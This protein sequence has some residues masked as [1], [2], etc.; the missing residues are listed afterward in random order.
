MLSEQRDGEPWLPVSS[1]SQTQVKSMRQVCSWLHVVGEHGA[2]S[3]RQER[4]E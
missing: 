1:H 3:N 4:E 2:L